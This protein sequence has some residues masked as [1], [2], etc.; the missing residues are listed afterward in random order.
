M[1]RPRDISFHIISLGCA[2][3]LV[4]SERINGEMA[5]RGFKN[6]SSPDTADILII[7]TCGFIEDAKRESIDVI[8][9][10]LSLK[11]SKE[12]RVNSAAA[13]GFK[14]RI[15]VAGCL[16]KRYRD[17]ISADIPEID[18]L[19]GLTDDS[20]IEELCRAFEID[21][22]R[23][24]HVGKPLDP[25]LPY[26]YLK[27]SEGCSNACSYC[28][29]PLIRGG[30]ISFAPGDI[31]M[32]A[33]RAVDEGARELVLIAQDTAAYEYGDLGLPDLVK[34]VARIGGVEW[35]RLMY[36][37]PDH[38]DDSIVRLFEECEK[39]VKYIDI[40]FQHASKKILASMG[41]RG[42]A[43]S[44]L[45]LIER[46]RARIPGI[47]IR[48]TFMT[49][50]PGET[51]E[52]F[53]RLLDFLKEARI[54]R[55]GCFAYSREEGTRAA[56][57]TAQVPQRVRTAR[58]RRLMRLQQKISLARLE[59]TVGSVIP[60]L[61]EARIDERTWAG[62]TQYDAPEVDGIFYLTGE[63]DM[64]NSIVT[65]RVTGCAEYDLFGVPV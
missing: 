19:Y 40:P 63:G 45:R 62:R 21:P 54:D 44:Y 52:D 15:V 57:L 20:F 24:S 50:Y 49:G 60:V 33:R 13:R 28:A 58:H 26:R 38:V 27:I 65:A 43:G 61:V 46:L 32:D 39:L 36:C 53:E 1:F 64:L 35:I 55:A 31:L 41:R 7:N 5:S 56:A 4:D 47:R 3:N 29:I 37:H 51:A 11:E 10:A 48:S 59:E 17:S 9:E 16:S 14:R 12:G 6:A 22:G 34:A 18:F 8:F 25:S 42:D 23:G 30:R 2:K